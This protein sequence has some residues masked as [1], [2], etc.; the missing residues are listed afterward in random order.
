V[1]SLAPATSGTIPAVL[2]VATTVTATTVHREAASVMVASP[3]Y[4]SRPQPATSGATSSVRM[5][6][7]EPLVTPV[8]PVSG[9]V[10]PV[11]R[12]SVV[13]PRSLTSG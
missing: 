8:S 3:W 12:K 7:L 6:V 9:V 4:V 1:P 13:V 11:R 2:T 10:P 5:D